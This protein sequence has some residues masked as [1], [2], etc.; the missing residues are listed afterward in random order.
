MTTTVQNVILLTVDC[1]RADH[2]SGYGYERETTPTLDRF[3]EGGVTFSNA[4]SAS[5]HT[6]E[7]VSSILSGQ[8]PDVAVDDR[9]QLAVESVASTLSNAEMA[10]GAFHSNPYISRAYGYQDGFD[11]FNDDLYIGDS[12][13]LALAQRLWDK[14]RGRHY[15]PAKVINERALAWVDSLAESKPF[16][17]WN[18]YMDPHGPY[19]PPDEYQRTY[20][21]E[22]ISNRRTQN[23]YRRSISD[24]ESLDKHDREQQL[25]LYDGEIRYFDDCLK[26]FLTALERR[27]HLENSL[28]IITADH[29]DAFGE[30]GY[31][32]HP[33]RVEPEV[34]HIPL[35]ARGP[36][37]PFQSV[38]APAST[39]DIV[40]TI[41][42]FTDT[43]TREETTGTSL[44]RLWR[45]NADP[46]P[47]FAQATSET[48]DTRR[49]GAFNGDG[50]S[51]CQ[52]DL[53]ACNISEFTGNGDKRL[54]AAL[55]DHVQS[56]IDSASGRQATPHSNKAVDS[57]VTDR[58][59]ALGYKE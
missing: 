9:Y 18:H 57:G 28:V 41:H 6:R 31:Y 59:E 3:S 16:F 44:T 7:A 29:G 14:F 36:M 52:V 45:S 32:G 17:L 58:L 25:D 47:V 15:A 34:T 5:S 37:I 43:E 20:H 50:A 19:N 33:R 8:Y 11:E 23:L 35:V 27:G 21:G 39:L 54:T 56:R 42:K 24:P 48:G 10:T 22:I 46:R 4:Y 2:V 13:L 30:H 1:L 12:K 40:P 51:Y 55:E 26:G 49:F 38:D 53:K